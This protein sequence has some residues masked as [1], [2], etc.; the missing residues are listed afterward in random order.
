MKSLFLEV[1]ANSNCAYPSK[2]TNIWVWEGCGY[3]PKSIDVSKDSYNIEHAIT[4]LELLN[5]NILNNFVELRKSS[6]LL[7][8]VYEIVDHSMLNASIV[9]RAYY[10]QACSDKDMD[11]KIILRKTLRDTYNRI[12][13]IYC[14]YGLNLNI[15]N[16]K[17][18]YVPFWYESKEESLKACY[19]LFEEQQIKNEREHF[20]VTKKWLTFQGILEEMT[21]FRGAGRVIHK[22][23]DDPNRT[24]F[25][26][27]WTNKEGKST[28]DQQWMNFIEK[29]CLSDN[30]KLK[31]AGLFIKSWY[32]DAT[33]KEGENTAL[34][35]LLQLSWDERENI[36]D[37]KSDF[38]PFYA[39]QFEVKCPKDKEKLSEYY[40]KYTRFW[41][42]EYPKK[43]NFQFYY[44]YPEIF[45]S[46]LKDSNLDQA[47]LIY[48]L[49]INYKAAIKNKTNYDY[50]NNLI[51][52]LL[53]KYPE[54]I[55]SEEKSLKVSRIWTPF[56][57]DKNH[58]GWNFSI[59][60]IAECN[61]NL[62]V[63]ASLH[64]FLI[65]SD[66]SSETIDFPPKKYG[67][68]FFDVSNRFVIGL[69]GNNG[70][71]IIYD[72]VEKKWNEYEI[73]QKDYKSIKIIKGNVFI[74]FVSGEKNENPDSGIIKLNLENGQS[75][76]IADSRRKPPQSPLDN[77]QPYNIDN[78]LQIEPDI[79]L[80]S[81]IHREKPLSPDY[82]AYDVSNNKW[83]EL[84]SLDE[85]I[86]KKIF[87]HKITLEYFTESKDIYERYVYG[88]CILPIFAMNQN[89]TIC[90]HYN[91]TKDISPKLANLEEWKS[92]GKYL[93]PF[94]KNYFYN[95]KSGLFLTENAESPS[96]NICLL[97]FNNNKTDGVEIP[98]EFEMNKEKYELLADKFKLS[99]REDYSKGIT[100]SND[101]VW[102]EGTGLFVKNN[103]SKILWFIPQS[104]LEE[105]L[106]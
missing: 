84:L 53:Q 97:I 50:T 68:S 29:L 7:V 82:L 65:K 5:R 54:L 26:V 10:D 77:I 16:I 80:F 44:R 60:H 1:K 92:S 74:A 13:Q 8:Q 103:D 58:D 40:F 18:A 71:I 17:A 21:L 59:N 55:K 28:L 96:T 101:C 35:E 70:K 34:N 25:L 23:I 11:K 27:D 20:Y 42:D 105:Y 69:N 48:P 3:N 52:C 67:Y 79:V 86:L 89:K 66:L 94:I 49:L 33:G 93:K 76:I 88:G 85:K 32:F 39:N 102:L 43:S 9:L 30:L 78:M 46:W 14:T 75:D 41:L 83:T 38:P 12:E 24:P 63:I 62:C 87:R 72:M 73:T 37:G 2:Q 81:I 64:I 100:Y 36:A 98:L 95:S 6:T 90:L 99:K 106:K 51:K 91:D 31:Y 15:F 19:E 45:N 4:S 57:S 47:L 56:E 104:D 22:N 61:S